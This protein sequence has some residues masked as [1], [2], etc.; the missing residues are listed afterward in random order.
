MGIVLKE[1]K[2]CR[3]A[4]KIIMKKELIKP[5]AKLENVYNETEQLIAIIAKGIATARK[6]DKK[7]M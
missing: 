2:E 6:N 3:I 4:I 5:L 7:N 1:L